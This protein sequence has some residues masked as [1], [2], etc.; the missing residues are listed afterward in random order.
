MI[1]NMTLS[2][3]AFGRMTLS[4]ATLG[5]MTSSRAKFGGISVL[6]ALPRYVDSY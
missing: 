6:L 1:G 4:R 2:R 5:R 3:I